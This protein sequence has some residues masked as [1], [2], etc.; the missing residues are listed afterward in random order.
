MSEKTTPPSE[1]A[2][3]VARLMPALLVWANC[4]MTDWLRA[5]ID[6]ADP[7]LQTHREAEPHAARLVTQSEEARLAYLRRALS[8]NL[9]YAVRKFGRSQG[10]VSL[11]VLVASSVRLVNWL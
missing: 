9:I 2:D 1:W 11:D 7:A 8:H 4:Q 10:E 3:A 6:T 5:E